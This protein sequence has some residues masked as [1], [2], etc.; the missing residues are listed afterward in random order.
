MVF[1][2][3]SIKK[4]AIKKVADALTG[5]GGNRVF[6]GDN[7]PELVGDALPFTIKMYESLLDFIPG[8]R[9]LQLRTGSLYI[10][11]ANAFLD[12]PASM[13]TDEEYKKQEFLMQ[14]AKNLYLRGRNILL[15]ALEK[16]HPGFRKNLDQR[17]FE[18]ALSSMKKDDV[19][20]LYWAG[21]GWM[22]AYAIDPF[23]MDLGLTLPGAAA[24]MERVLKLDKKFGEGA[25]HNFY[26]LYYGSL[27]EYMGG[28]S[29]KARKHFEKAIEVS[30]INVTSPHISLATT[31]SIKDQK[32][33]EFKQLLNK[34]LEIDLDADPD[35]RLLHTLNQRKA[36][37]LLE[38][39]EDYF[40]PKEVEKNELEDLNQKEAEDNK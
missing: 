3:C 36:R 29:K 14:R 22:G 32:V 30:G 25:I 9:G 38:H 13:L 7:D 39:V 5:P 10:M 15:N 12:T 1:S 16:K 23:D 35:N 33:K 27:P 17:K 19:E 31:V 37:W 24:L 20:L 4:F 18:Q 6:T 11:Y 2:S 26:I 40:L 8:H 21:A 34:V 28:D